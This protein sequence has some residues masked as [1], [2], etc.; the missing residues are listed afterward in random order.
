MPLAKFNKQIEIMAIRRVKVFAHSSVLL[1]GALIL[2]LGW[3]YPLISLAKMV[4]YFLIILTHECGHMVAAQRKGC[5]V[6]SI[7]LYPF[8]GVTNFSEPYSRLDH[9]VIAWAGVVAQAI[10][11]L[12]LIAWVELFGYTR[13][14]AVNEILNVLGF[15]SIVIAAFNLFPIAPLDGKI[16]WGLFPALL[17][18]KSSR[19]P[20]RAPAWRSWR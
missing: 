9:C 10:V 11:A 20:K 1:I 8:W 17:K 13:L 7:E 18:R 5:Y 19:M 6:S 2:L 4:S 12:P 3:R 16:A 15:Y 14:D